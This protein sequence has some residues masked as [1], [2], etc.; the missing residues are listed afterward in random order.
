[1]IPVSKPYLPSLE[2]YSKFLKI[3]WENN[4]LTNNGPLV[5]RL[6]NEIT[7]YLNVDKVYYVT[8]G[9]T[10]LQLAIKALG[11]TKEIITT[12][13]SFVA[14]TT[15]I[16][17]ESC[18]PVFVDIESNTF[19]INADLI[20]SAIT[21]KTEAILATHVFGYPCDVI[22]I[23]KIAEKYGLK[24][25][26]DGAHA[27][28]SIING[29]SLLSYGDI[30]TVSFHATKLFHTIEG[31]AVIVNREESIVNELSLLRSFGNVG[32]NHISPG[33]NGKNSEFHAAM[34]LCNL[35][36]LNHIIEKRKHLSK[37]Y[38]ANIKGFFQLPKPLYEFEYNY[39][40][41]PM[42]LKCESE[43]LHVKAKLEEHGILARRY[44]YPSLNKISYL[45]NKLTLKVSED[46]ASRILCLPLFHQIENE[47]LERI[48]SIVNKINQKRV[49]K[50]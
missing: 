9:T 27:F 13:F 12:P 41:Y 24:V 6:E 37:F 46:I 15:S 18:T 3:I 26:Y 5:R 33:V 38:D 32:D 22:K 48:V 28:G 40:Y 29:K 11:L 49:E 30:S 47:E 20:E 7:E 36:I 23:Q 31:G 42:I 45:N 19:C 43:L 25:I 44:F 16:I 21:E 34:G 39:A 50:I 10:A 2:E 17:W 8:N 4:Q 1:M 14:T 35:P